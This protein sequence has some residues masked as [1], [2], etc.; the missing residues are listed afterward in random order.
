MGLK[1]VVIG[2]GSSYTPEIIEGLIDRYHRFPVTSV[3]L[4]DV[5]EGEEKMKT[6][7]SLSRRMIAEA[8][9]PVEIHA[10]KDRKK[11][12]HHA[13]FVMVQVRV[14]GLQARYYDE[15]IPLKHRLIGQETNGAGGIFNALRTVPVLLDIAQDMHNICPEAWL[16]NFSNPAGIVTEAVLKHSPH[17]KVVGVCNI[18]Y[19]MRTGI[20]SLFGVGIERI[21]VEFLGLNHFSF[22]KRVFIDGKDRT[23]ETIEKLINQDVDYAPANIVSLP[24]NKTFLSMIGM[25]PNPYHQYYF[26]QETMLEKDIKQWKE[27]GTRAEMVMQVEKHLFRQYA[28]ESVKAK[29]KELEERGGAYYSDAACNLMVSMYNNVLDVQTVNTR[30]NGCLPELADDAVIEVNSLITADGPRP[31]AVGSIP[32]QTSGLLIQMKKMEE[33]V[34]EAAVTGNYY[35]TYAA[36]VMNPLIRSDEKA[37]IVLDELLEAHK[38]FLPQFTKGV[39]RS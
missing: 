6:V 23:S 18:P 32:R 27:Q 10:G 1:L 13:D 3:V 14:G 17:Q 9:L 7:A 33:L 29:P 8:G 39:V 35:S 21:S 22:G 30:N 2:G 16:I 25:I 15:Q 11:A 31:I 36:F 28:D 20:A 34:I 19:N 37:Q 26:Q 5:A 38:D 4:V 12:L 24:W